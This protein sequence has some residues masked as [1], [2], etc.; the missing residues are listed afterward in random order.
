MAGCNIMSVLVD[1]RT[2]QAVEVQKVLTEEGCMIKT[3]LGIHETSDDL[4][5]DIGII[6]LNLRG[7]DEEIAS[8]E[9]KLN[10]IKGVTARNTKLCY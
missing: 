4:C 8:L 7:T 6:I 5:S 3:R 2:N 1:S 10:S 9:K